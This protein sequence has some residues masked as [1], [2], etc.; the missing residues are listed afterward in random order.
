MP[1]PSILLATAPSPEGPLELRQRGKDFLLL[2]NGRMLMNSASQ[3]SEQALATLGCAPI[4]GRRAPRV[5]IGGLGMGLTLR[6]ALDVLP[7]EAE[8]V[9]AELTPTIVD[10]CR[11]PLGALTGEAV[12]DPRVSVVVG[13]VA[14]V[15]AQALGGSFDAI[16]LDLYE[17]PHSATQRRED[18]FYGPQALVR[19]RAALRPGGVLGVWAEELAPGFTARMEAAGF[20]A[21][22][23]RPG[24]GGRAHVVYVGVR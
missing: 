11:G 20:G 24:R 14:R 1:S 8:V 5:L 3:R 18:P 19:A 17:G 7:A 6:A 10:W 23:H 9:V 22:V 13:D 4:L 15:I 2:V 16:L 21:T 12:G